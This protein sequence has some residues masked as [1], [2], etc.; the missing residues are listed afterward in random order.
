[1][2]EIRVIID[3]GQSF[4]FGALTREEKELLFDQMAEENPDLPRYT[5]DSFAKMQDDLLG[6]RDRDDKPTL[7]ELLLRKVI[8][9]SKKNSNYNTLIIPIIPSFNQT[10]VS[11][12]S[13]KKSERKNIKVRFDSRILSVTEDGLDY[14]FPPNEEMNII[15]IIINPVCGKV[16]GIGGKP[17]ALEMSSDVTN[18][19]GPISLVG[20]LIPIGNYSY[21]NASSACDNYYIRPDYSLTVAGEVIDQN[22]KNNQIMFSDL[23]DEKIKTTL[24]SIFEYI[25]GIDK[26]HRSSEAALFIFAQLKAGL[27]EKKTSIT[28]KLER[29]VGEIIKHDELTDFR[30]KQPDKLPILLTLESIHR[31]SFCTVYQG[32]L[33]ADLDKRGFSQIYYRS[34][35]KG[36][37]DPSV[38]DYLNKYKDR[39]SRITF[40]NKLKEKT[41][42]ERNALNSYKNIIESKLGVKRL[43]EVESELS[44]KPSLA[45]S[46]GILEILKPGEKK[47]VVLESDKRQKY[48]EAVV[49][50]KCPHV[51]IYKQLRRSINDENTRK[52]YNNLKKYFKNPKETSNMIQCN[53]CGFD[54]ICPHVKDFSEMEL[55][56]KFQSEIK[57][58]LT[59]YIDKST[60]REQFYCKI[61][62]ETMSSLEVFQD[63]NDI[64]REDVTTMNEELKNFMWSE[65]IPLTRFLKFGTLVNVP[66]LVTAMRNACYPYIFEIEKHILKS[67]TNS[68]EEIKSKKKLFVT[69]Y[70]FAYMIRV[71]TAKN[72]EISFR[73]FKPRSSNIVVDLIKHCIDVIM[74]ARNVIIREIPGMSAEIIKNKLI[75]A[76]KSLQ[77]T[78]SHV[79]SYGESEDTLTT[80]LLD[81]V[82]KYIYFLNVVNDALLGKKPSKS[83]MDIVDKVD[84]LVGPIARL[85][86]SQDIYGE[87]KIPTKWN[88][89]AFDNIQPIRQASRAGS[90]WTE[91]QAGFISRSF[92]IFHDKL[93]QRLFTEPMYIDISASGKDDPTAPMNVEFREPFKAHLE[94]YL[95]FAPKEELLYR[96]KKLSSVGLYNIIRTSGSR[97]WKDPSATL[98]RIFDEDGAP[99]VWSIYITEIIGKDGKTEK[100][101]LS[102]SDINGYVMN[103]IKFTS[104]IKDKK[105][106]VCGVLASSCGKLD[107]KKIRESLNARHTVINF[108][109]FYENRCPEESIHV[110]KAAKCEKC[111]IMDDYFMKP[112]SKPSMAY[113]REY[114]DKYIKERE[115]FTNREIAVVSPPKPPADVS[116]HAPTYEKWTFN[117]NLVLD[118]AGKTKVNHRLITAIGAV[119]KQKYTDVSSG[120]YIPTEAE[121]RDDTRIYVVNGYVK[122]IIMDYNQLKYFHRSTKPSLVISQL[123]EESGIDKHRLADLEKKLPDIYNDYND[124]F[125][126]V[127]RN[128]K[129]REV[130]NF[131]IQSMCEMY[132]RIWDDTTKE[133]EKIR[134]SFVDY[135]IKKILRSDELVSKPGVFNWSLLYD[136]KTSD[137]SER[138]SNY[139]ENNEVEAD[140]TDEEN[141]N[142]FSMNAFDVEEDPDGDPDDTGNE[143]KVGENYGMD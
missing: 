142:P 119:E 53:N 11:S 60:V 42:T 56:G 84:T 58:K 20:P 111:G 109:R 125:T 28:P 59:H 35:I 5:I 3:Q 72:S 91:A 31:G 54:I 27:E 100:K 87:I 116:K 141:D 15:G 30:S 140:D 137:A 115:E 26:Y 46:K 24:D 39:Q 92:D 8:N 61:C 133:T 127:H 49:N 75:E 123:V 34:L 10:Y 33:L 25:R 50:N 135:S 82:Y 96:Y 108:F 78:S 101:E 17:L 65:M 106:S 67:K 128:K 126:Y 110:F 143:I 6:E 107:E 12:R 93:K 66:Q 74:S 38:I 76:Y 138:D 97:R 114:K 81:P 64:R 36:K 89:S 47:I 51:K 22:A 4:D 104:N 95:Q 14:I 43:L 112:M 120:V 124:R 85:E 130:V 19:T 32:A 121:H 129:P 45:T 132:L 117:F 83:K 103:G 57:S 63:A 7:I 70:A 79:I 37:D 69:I 113:Y 2:T 13:V 105:C 88:T 18:S 122:N 94:K 80:L 29:A 16:G 86:K 131:V 98:G 62:G 23:D 90:V 44:K 40:R 77:K 1:M 73:D 9:L 55:A 139:N 99:H 136:T 118:L 71:V 48:L 102:L 41:L 134:H 52:I 21:E 68:M